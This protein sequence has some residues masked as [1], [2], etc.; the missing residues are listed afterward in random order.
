MAPPEQ[1]SS[2]PSPTTMTTGAN[3]NHTSQYDL[4]LSAKPL[5]FKEISSFRSDKSSSET[6]SNNNG[7]NSVS[8]SSNK[9]DGTYA[10]QTRL[11]RLPIPSLEDTLKKFPLVLEALQDDAKQRDET[12]RVVQEFLH[13]EGPIL[14][15]ALIDYERAG[16]ESGDIGSYVE[17]FW[18]ESY[19]S[20]DTSVVLNLN[21][22][23]VLEDG[24]DPTRAVDQ[25]ARAASLVLA[26][27]KIASA[28]RHETMAPDVFKGRPLCMDQYKA[29]FGASRQPTEHADLASSC[30]EVHVY[31]DSSHVVVMCNNQFYYFPALWTHSGHVAVDETDVLEI[32]RAI[33]THA[34]KS[35]TQ[36]EATKT[37]LGVF[38]SLKRSEWFLARQELCAVEKNESAL[39]IIDSAL[40][41]LVLD[42]YAPTDPHSMGANFLHGT[43]Q[44]A[45]GDTLQVGTCLNR[46][47]DKLQLIVCKDGT[48]GVNFEHSAIDGH[49]ALRFVSDMYAETIINFAESIVDLI[50]GRGCIQHIVDA[51]VIRAAATSDQTACGKPLL[52]VYPRKIVF[53]LPDSV[54]ERIYYAET[55]LCDEVAASDTYVLEFK[56]FGKS[57]I[58]GNKISPDSFVQMSIM[59]AYYKLYGK[60]VCTYEP[61]LTKAFFHGRTEAMRSA[62]P[63]AKKL[64]QLWCKKS[65]SPEEKLDALRTATMEHSR[66]VREASMGM[67]VDRH[68]FSL[69][70]IGARMGIHPPFF[71]SEAWKTLNHTILSTSNCGNPALRFF[72]FGP[73]VP[74]GFGVGYIIKD[75]GLSFSVSSKHR[76]T[77]RFV[78]SLNNALK[79][80][81]ALLQPIG[82]MEVA[83]K[84]VTFREHHGLTSYDD[85]YG[86]AAMGSE[87]ENE[88]NN[89][90]SDFVLLNQ[91]RRGSY[92]KVVKEREKSFVVLDDPDLRIRLNLDGE[93]APAAD[94]CL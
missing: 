24:P 63:Q 36:L 17:E 8:A 31:K 33:Q 80:M 23:F 9:M 82:K 14:Q 54:K 39:H 21:P 67:A 3:T 72:G 41:V 93:H 86:E 34:H 56:D 62:T 1:Q 4:N 45:E 88:N 90:D 94:Q 92:L 79:E 42:D 7:N 81:Q 49:T 52:D 18:N 71:Q 65:A 66:L 6:D 84:T 76:Q 5:K 64:C 35:I 87:D 46:W 70:R 43:N 60:I 38:T 26:S 74:D 2:I 22:F 40:F 48:A 12:Q 75:Y 19:L 50:H 58:V 27:L 51:Q 25:L 77:Q 13:N 57:L 15:Q 11:P 85:I 55:A 59:L 32:L 89:P 20:P 68:L 29:L 78:R 73:V 44:L 91:K 37:A 47:Y 10:A 61:V 83:H 28:L 53:E 69:M 16:V 30:D